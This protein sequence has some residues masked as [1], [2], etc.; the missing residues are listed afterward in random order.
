MFITLILVVIVMVMDAISAR[1]RQRYIVGKAIPLFN[2]G[3]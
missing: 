1:L 2:Q 3:E